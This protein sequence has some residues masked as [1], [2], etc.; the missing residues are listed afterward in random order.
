MRLESCK[1]NQKEVKA[2]SRVLDRIEELDILSEFGQDLNLEALKKFITVEKF[3]DLGAEWKWEDLG[4]VICNIIT[5]VIDEEEYV[6]EFSKV[7]ITT[8]Q[9][10]YSL[11][12]YKLFEYFNK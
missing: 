2:L 3:N 4:I 11:K 7:D 5:Q 10:Y 8:L 12:G 9:C 6:N 1:L